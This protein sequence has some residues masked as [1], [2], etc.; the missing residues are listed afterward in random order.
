MLP[1]YIAVLTCQMDITRTQSPQ[2]S[3][4]GAIGERPSKTSSHARSSSLAGAPR[5]PLGGKQSS[6]DD[7]DLPTL[8]SHGQRQLD[9]D[10]SRF[11]RFGIPPAPASAGAAPLRGRTGMGAESNDSPSRWAEEWRE[12][13]P[14]SRDTSMQRQVS[15]TGATSTSTLAFKDQGFPSPIGRR[16]FAAA[17]TPSSSD[18]SVT[19]TH[20]L[21]A[22]SAV[23]NPLIAQSDEVIRLRA[24]VELW[25]GE[26][27]RCDRERRRLEA[28]VS[29]EDPAKGRP[30]FTVALIDGDGLIV[31]TWIPRLTAVQ[32]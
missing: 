29:T 11:G 1:T 23:L 21:N 22:L 24:E 3:P 5:T 4:H 13:T 15:S 26:W 18:P 9:L 19:A 32:R 20:H 27:Q 2:P 10:R 12:S 16:S 6:D 17:S 25:R 8:M 31:S 14:R 7:M 28:I 30:K